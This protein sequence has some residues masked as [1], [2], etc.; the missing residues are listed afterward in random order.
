MKTLSTV[1]VGA[2]ERSARALK[3]YER[4]IET[5]LNTILLDQEIPPRT[6]KITHTIAL[7]IGSDQGLVGRFNKS[8]IEHYAKHTRGKNTTLL[9]AGR[10]LI[11]RM[12]EV[13][14]P[15]TVFAMP[16]S[17]TMVASAIKNIIIRI[18]EL[19]RPDTELVV[20]HNKRNGG[21]YECVTERML[22]VPL[23]KLEHI[24]AHPRVGK[25]MPI[26]TSDFMGLF[27]DFTCQMLFVEMYRTLSESLACEH[28]IRMMT[29]QNA[30]KS[31]DERLDIMKIEYQ[32]R[33][34]DEITSELIDIV[35]G[36]AA[37]SNSASSEKK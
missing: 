22:P 19:M 13:Y 33:R 20:F 18:N 14:D 27:N 7:V 28:F 10:S 6:E 16:N 15:D 23:K 26:Y 37:A 30:E 5:S 8:L 3:E 21:T 12:G 32:T 4:N 24:K 34:Q 29:M 9:A 25:K 2:Y 35:S 31:I 36:Y 17:P 1:S 11:A